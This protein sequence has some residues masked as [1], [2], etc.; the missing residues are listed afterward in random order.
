M[1]QK[2]N[3]GISSQPIHS[4][5]RV[6]AECHSDDRV[7]EVEFDAAP[8]FNQASDQEIFDLA[9]CGWGG[10]YPSDAVAMDMAKHLDSIAALFV[11]LDNH[12]RSPRKHI[13]FECHVEREDA[14]NW[15]RAN[16][17]SLLIHIQDLEAA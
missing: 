12:N 15:L 8:W 11:Y 14:M 1:Q 13:G 2:I 7:F 9:E 4:S 16:R 5:A 6:R 10:D 3:D 17:P